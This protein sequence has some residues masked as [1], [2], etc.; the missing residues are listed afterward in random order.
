MMW[1]PSCLA[2]N[3]LHPSANDDGAQIAT[4]VRCR[5]WRAIADPMARFVD[6]AP[7]TLMG[8]RRQKVRRAQGLQRLLIRQRKNATSRNQ[9][10]FGRIFRRQ[11]HFHITAP[12]ALTI[13]AG[14][15]VLRWGFIGLYGWPATFT[16]ANSLHL[17]F[18]MLEAA[19]VLLWWR[20]RQGKSSGPLS[21]LGQWFAS[22]E[23]LG[24]SLITTARGR[25]LHQWEQH[26][27][28]RERLLEIEI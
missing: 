23:L 16:L 9:G 5:G 27:D 21:I 8:Q 17:G 24:R 14:A 11:F 20:A 13:G 2:I 7:S 6:V 10:L 12:L 18:S 1:R 15:A 3:E 25:S 4:S 22:M 26:G 19:C 28:V